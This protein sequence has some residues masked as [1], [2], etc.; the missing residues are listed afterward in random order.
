MARGVGKTHTL[1][2]KERVHALR[3]INLEVRAQEF[4]TIVGPSGC[5]KS[6]LVN[7]LTGLSQPDSGDIAI[8]ESKHAYTGGEHFT[9]RFIVTRFCQYGD[10]QFGQRFVQRAGNVRQ[11]F[12][13]R[14]IQINRA[15]GARTDGDF[16]HV[17][18]RRVEE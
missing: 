12:R 15:S 18:V 7:L 1:K 14:Q 9:D 11:I 5:G 17:H 3:E 10:G 16:F 13:Q 4:L 8:R 2:S 6:T